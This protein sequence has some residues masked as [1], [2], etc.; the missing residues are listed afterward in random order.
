MKLSV[1][2]FRFLVILLF[3]KNMGL[4]LGVQSSDQALNHVTSPDFS[5]VSQFQPV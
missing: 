2:E 1:Q 3:L 5:L 4:W